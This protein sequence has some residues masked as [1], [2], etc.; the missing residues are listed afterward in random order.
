MDLESNNVNK[1]AQ[2]NA[3]IANPRALA[4]E[5]ITDH[6]EGVETHSKLTKELHEI[7]KY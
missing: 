2:P 3:A 1:K 4:Y 6:Q 5:R 7:E